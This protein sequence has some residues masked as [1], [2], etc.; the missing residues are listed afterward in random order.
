[1]LMGVSFGFSYPAYPPVQA[2]MSPSLDSLPSGFVTLTVGDEMF[3]Y[4]NGTFY[5]KIVRDDKYV[6]TPPPIGA[7][8]FDIPPRYQYF[9]VDGE[10]YYVVRGVYYKRVLEGYRVIEPPLL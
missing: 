8:V 1:M 5:Q 6:V 3:Y 4:A 9:W 10:A 2:I 7:V